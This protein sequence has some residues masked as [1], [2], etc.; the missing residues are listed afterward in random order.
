MKF[1]VSKKILSDFVTQLAGW[2][3]RTAAC[4]LALVL[5]MGGAVAGEARPPDIVFF[6]ADDWGRDAGVYAQSG[7]ITLSDFVETP[8]ID[9]MAREGVRFNNA[10]YEAPQCAP[11]RAAIV[12]GRAFWR[13]GAAAIQRGG[14]WVGVRNS[15]RES[16]RFPDLLSD[17]GYLTARAFKTLPFQPSSE[18]ASIEGIDQFLRYGLHVSAAT[19]PTERTLRRAMV[20]QQTRDAIRQVVRAC[21]PDE[22][23]FFVFG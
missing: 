17:R 10:F 1:F 16:P 12:T 23:F 8:T 2:F 18:E 13:N 14:G 4:L 21:R 20:L 6:L 9:R 11:S 7:R 19:T 15:F 22:P 5:W 3:N